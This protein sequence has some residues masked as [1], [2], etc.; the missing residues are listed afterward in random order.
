R[1]RIHDDI[2]R[3]EVDPEMIH[4]ITVPSIREKIY[5]EISK[6]GFS[7]ITLDLKGYRTG[8]MNIDL[9]TPPPA[10]AG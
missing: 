2:L 10:A 4:D 6:I 8:S 5:E 9:I 7:Y 3:I 1:A